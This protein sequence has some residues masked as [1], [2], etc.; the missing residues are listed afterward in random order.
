MDEKAVR[1]KIYRMLYK[2]YNFWPNTSD[3]ARCRKCGTMPVE[4]GTPDL[5]VMHPDAASIV[6]EVKI[7]RPSERAF[8]MRRIKADQRK[9]LDRWKADGGCGYLGLGIIVPAGSKHSLASLSLIPWDV[10]KRMEED[11]K[12]IRVSI[13]MNNIDVS[14]LLHSFRVERVSGRWQLCAGHPILGVL[15][16]QAREQ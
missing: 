1:Q 3:R 7:V 13:P 9:W 6:I 11:F 4:K 15:G 16:I 2:T 5:L 8:P 12:G 10:W 14:R